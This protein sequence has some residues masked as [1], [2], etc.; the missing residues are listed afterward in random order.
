MARGTAARLSNAGES[1]APQLSAG[2]DE[3]LRDLSA[4]KLIG[5]VDTRVAMSFRATCPR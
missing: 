3:F 4:R 1:A 2:C 5:R